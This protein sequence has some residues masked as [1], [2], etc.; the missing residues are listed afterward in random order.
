MKFESALFPV[1]LIDFDFFTS[2]SALFSWISPAK[3]FLIELKL[4]T[5]LYSDTN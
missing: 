2:F 5:Q 4:K 1:F 3:L